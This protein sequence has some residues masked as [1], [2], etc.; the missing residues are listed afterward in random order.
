MTRWW[1]M[2]AI[3]ITYQSYTIRC[4]P[5]FLLRLILFSSFTDFIFVFEGLVADKSGRKPLPPSP[6]TLSSSSYEWKILSKFHLVN[7]LSFGDDVGTAQRPSY[8]YILQSSYPAAM[9]MQCTS[10]SIPAKNIMAYDDKKYNLYI[11]GGWGCR[12]KIERVAHEK[13]YI[14]R[15]KV[16]LLRRC[17]FFLFSHAA[18]LWLFHSRTRCPPNMAT[19]F[20]PI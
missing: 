18:P 10:L 14:P 4:R 19:L 13:C 8:Y 15:A 9:C 5:F 11:R 20:V 2:L 1:C 16:N 12:G 7:L 17:C 6:P 3:N